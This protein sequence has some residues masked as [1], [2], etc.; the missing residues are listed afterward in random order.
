ML[1]I[2]DQTLHH[3]LSAKSQG[4]P[5]EGF[6]LDFITLLESVTTKLSDALAAL[7]GQKG[8]SSLAEPPFPTPA[9]SSAIR[10]SSAS[11]ASDRKSFHSGYYSLRPEHASTSTN[12]TSLGGERDQSTE[13]GVDAAIPR[14]VE[15]QK[16]A[17]NRLEE[18]ACQ[19]GRPSSAFADPMSAEIDQATSMILREGSQDGKCR[20]RIV[21]PDAPKTDGEHDSEGWQTYAR[22]L[23]DVPSS[24]PVPQPQAIPN[25]TFDAEQ[26]HQDTA[27]TRQDRSTTEIRTATGQAV[28]RSDRPYGG[29]TFG[30]DRTDTTVNVAA[31]SLKPTLS[32]SGIE[33]VEDG[34]SGKRAT[35]RSQVTVEEKMV[36]HWSVASLEARD[37]KEVCEGYAHTGMGKALIPLW[38]QD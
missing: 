7:E 6:V 30:V 26:Q 36:S 38:V 27:G 34:R 32:I 25:L 1:N 33:V 31:M 37:V 11:T 12:R 17:D 13:N 22:D 24:L 16:T 8:T 9:P 20:Y 5:D 2:L 29:G 28:S 4:T 15:R 23:A 35:P 14:I 3:H 21:N 10:S 18:I 19:S